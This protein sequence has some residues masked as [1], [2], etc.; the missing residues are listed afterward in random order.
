KWKTT[1]RAT[2]SA[3]L[4]AV[5][6]AVVVLST[7]AYAYAFTRIY[8][9]P[10]TRVSASRWIY[11]NLPGP[12][13]VILETPE[14]RQQIPLATAG[15]QVLQ[16]GL[17]WTASFSP[18]VSGTVT[19]VTAPHVTRHG[20][21]TDQG[22]EP[23][24]TLRL[25]LT[26][27]DAAGTQ[28]AA[29]SK[30][31]DS[32]ALP[33][34][35]DGSSSQ[36]QALEFELGPAAVEAGQPYALTLHLS[37]GAPLA[38]SG[39]AIAV[40][41][42][43]DDTLPLSVD[44]YVPY[45]GLYQ[46]LDLEL[47]KA[48]T[49]LKRQQMLEV[50]NQADYIVIASNRS[51]DAMP[52]LP[53]RFPLTT[54]F[55]RALFGCDTG[56]L[57][58]CAYSAAPPL[59]GNLGFDLV[60]TF[61]SYPT[62]G[63]W[64]IPDQTAQESFTVY[65]HPK[66]LVFQKA[67]DYS[68]A[69]VSALLEAVDL[70]QIILQSAKQVSQAPS[71]LR[72]PAAR[73]ADQKAAGTWTDLFSPSSLLNLSQPMAVVGWLLLLLLIGWLIFP[74]TFAAFSGLPDRGYALTRL[75]GLLIVAWLAWM[76]A[77][78]RFAP[79]TTATLW[80]CLALAAVLSGL[81]AW[82]SRAPLGAFLRARWRHLLFVEGLFLVLFLF[83]LLL[84]WNNPDLWH[85]WRGG[86][87]PGDLALLN[88][89]LKSASFP[90][91]DPWLS[92]NYVNYY[93]F[94]YV[95]AAV[96]V[97]LL[98]I[99][100]AVAYNLLIPTWFA[101]TGLGAFAVA[102]NLVAGRSPADP[103]AE[104]EAQGRKA[105]YLAGLAAL[106]L[107]LL[108]GNLYEFQL[109]SQRLLTGGGDLLAGDA[110][111]WYFDAS[112][113]I[114]NGQPAAP[115]TEFPFFTFLYADLHP[116]L[117]DMPIVLAALAWLLSFLFAPVLLSRLA[118]RWRASSLVTTWLV[119]GLLLGATY[120][121]NTWDFPVL[122]SLGALVVGYA[123]WTH[124]HGDS[125]AR[126]GRLL[127]HVPLLLFLSVV[128]YAPFRQWFGAGAQG[129]ER[130]SGP[131]TPL[132]DYLTVHGLFL[133]L[134]ATFLVI[135][136]A[137]TL[138]PWVQRFIHTPLGEMIS[139]LKWGGILLLVGLPTVLV[140]AIWAWRNDYQSVALALPLALWAGLLLLR[141][142]QT[143][144]QRFALLL[145]TAGIGLTLIAELVTLKGDVGRMNVVFK[146]Y[147]L[148]WTFFSI[149][150]GASLVWARARFRSDDRRWLWWGMLAFLVVAAS[151]YPVLGSLAKARDR[152]PDVANPPRT[153]DGMAFMLGEAVEAAGS[154]TYVEEGQ[155]L[156][157]ADDY[158][159]LRWMQANVSGTPTIVEAHTPEYRWGSRFSVYTGLPTVVGW[160][161]HLRQHNAVLP[162]S[163]V[164]NRIAAVSNF[165][166]TPSR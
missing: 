157:L 58:D 82:R 100:P 104:P 60:A 30:T 72:L 20:D 93:Y 142:D 122:A 96:P 97:K 59:E 80:L 112:R 78:Y 102:Y 11:Q 61:E 53:L 101:L 90:P 125:R 62:L 54:A 114:L 85:P 115:I 2:I 86:E 103:E 41:S 71:G 165:Y 66:V 49:E 107:M 70:S 95:L 15:E 145:V 88:A 48:D 164:E 120:P 33:A 129:V 119:G 3:G 23:P 22:G 56:P 108:L 6:L 113:A 162:G 31:L 118:V 55:Y 57:T 121:T 69:R 109:L 52:R 124:P 10:H 84:R 166:N 137:R 68:S 14:G 29:A 37:D 34:T 154:V 39:T 32:T 19:A 73:L 46:P 42:T 110:G 24:A 138:R 139:T 77:S 132:S 26:R 141:K 98:G 99:A 43:W 65:D 161:W 8:T 148:V 47:H 155:E 117:L 1:R 36:P 51:Y 151:T 133:F 25:A 67:P 146:F 116:H 147:L 50:L 130:W 83:G 17:P 143:P 106:A 136:T 12:I 81:V 44:G 9:R 87:K 152:W 135:E 153:L 21:G 4:A 159:A 13:N 126:I 105:P 128:L 160:S 150:A 91:Y 16:P 5:L 7:Y 63:P 89:V 64:S 92:G 40:E 134:L 140:A 38:L 76:A 35:L 131:R 144:N 75:V 94:G 74:L 127:V 158:E 156:H 79:S 111:P 123:A 45:S 27:G 163:V 149:A 18:A 28:L